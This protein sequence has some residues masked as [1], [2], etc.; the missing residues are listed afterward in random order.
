M[1]RMDDLVR[2][3]KA[4]IVGATAGVVGGAVAGAKI[5]AGIGIATGGTAIVGTVPLGILGGAVRGLAGSRLGKLIDD[6]RN[7]KDDDPEPD[8]T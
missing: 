8:E 7:R 1:S 4:E 5:G 3:C 2:R 6:I